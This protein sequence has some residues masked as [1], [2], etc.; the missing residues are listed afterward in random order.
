[1]RELTVR[2]LAFPSEHDPEKWY[3]FSRTN[4]NRFVRRSC[5]NKELAQAFDALSRNSCDMAVGCTPATPFAVA[6]R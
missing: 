5:S 4:G 1:M 2:G 3:R 6:V